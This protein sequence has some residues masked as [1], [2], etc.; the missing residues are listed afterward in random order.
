MGARVDLL[1]WE[2]VVAAPLARARYAELLESQRIRSLVSRACDEAARLSSVA[3]ERG[4]IADSLAAAGLAAGAPAASLASAEKLRAPRCAAVITG[5][6][7]GYLGGPLFT[8]WK[9]AH[10]V[11]LARAVERDSGIPCVPLFW[12]HSDDHDLDET[13]GIALPDAEGAVR[14]FALDLGR[15]RPFLA[16]VLV[17]ASADEVNARVAECLPGGPD[18]DRVLSLAFPRP[19][20][21]FAASTTRLLLGCFGESGLVVFEPRDLRGPLARALA[22]CVRDAPAGLARLVRHGEATRRSGLEPPFDTGDPALLFERTRAGRE[23]VRWVESHFSL[24]DGGRLGPE[25][26][27]GAIERDPERFSAGVASRCAA[28]ALALPVAAT[29][30]GPGELAYTPSAYCFLPGDAPRSAPVEIPRFAATLVEAKIAATAASLGLAPVDVVREGEALLA[31]FPAPPAHDAESRLESLG[32][33]IRSHLSDLAPSLAAL[34]PNL[35]RPLEKTAATA[36]GALEAL[37]A[38]VRRSVEERA[39]VGGSRA[40]RLLA[41]LR[42]NQQFQERALPCVPFLCGGLERRVGE[43]LEILD[44]S[45]RGHAVVTFAESQRS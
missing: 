29:I 35:A 25:D 19:G 13:R 45:P 4:A 39:A 10:A 3:F 31:R 22:R 27:A 24:P 33:E 7:P 1:P 5:Q 41:W 15:G 30:R 23:R 6:Q 32:S 42:P 26:L 14:R 2:D 17:P 44:P 34:D 28:E 38:R 37:R 18:R 43:I 40:R 16:D 9:A 8:F 20:E 11:A 21:R 36:S 12:N